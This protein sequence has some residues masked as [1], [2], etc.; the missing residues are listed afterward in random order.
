MNQLH[1][2]LHQQQ[3]CHEG[4]TASAR[5]YTITLIFSSTSWIQ[6][7]LENAKNRRLSVAIKTLK[8]CIYKLFLSLQKITKRCLFVPKGS[9]HLRAFPPSSNPR[10][11]KGWS[12]ASQAPGLMSNT[13]AGSL[14]P[15]LVAVALCWGYAL[16]SLQKQGSDFTHCILN[17][18]PSTSLLLFL[19]FYTRPFVS[20]LLI[21][22]VY[23][24]RYCRVVSVHLL[25]W[26][27][28]KPAG[29]SHPDPSSTHCSTHP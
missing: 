14:S 20:R 24:Y 9:F 19:S 11:F 6:N 29:R 2:Y 7:F 15:G 23:S 1:E 25:C 26:T 21:P 12:T 8:I 18:N 3:M 17:P 4:K 16:N 27:S 5:A 22:T 28:W 10:V 13:Q